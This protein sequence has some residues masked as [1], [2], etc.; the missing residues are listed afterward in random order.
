MKQR[1]GPL[2]LEREV[3]GVRHYVDDSQWRRLRI[4]ARLR[5]VRQ[6]DNVHDVNAIALEYADD[7]GA[8]QLGF[9]PRLFAQMLAPLLDRQLIGVTCKI[10]DMHYDTGLI[11]FKLHLVE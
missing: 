2:L 6:P 3:A 10:S 7:A 1:K 9:I 5:L 8:F 4:G 11:M